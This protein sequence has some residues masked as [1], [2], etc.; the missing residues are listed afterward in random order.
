[1]GINSNRISYVVLDEAD[2]LLSDRSWLPQVRAALDMLRPD[3]QMLM[4]SATWPQEAERVALDICGP[5]L[6]RIRVDPAVP[7]IPQEVRLFHGAG[8]PESSESFK[9]RRQ[10]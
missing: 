4:L 9:K 5:E 2:E 8:G 7:S 6:V 10:A 1:M 3:R